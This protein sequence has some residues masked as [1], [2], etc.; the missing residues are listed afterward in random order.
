MAT[1]YFNPRFVFRIHTDLYA[2]NF[3]RVLAAYVTARHDGT[4]GQGLAEWVTDHEPE[5]R[6][7]F[8]QLC[9]PY[10]DDN[11][12]PRYVT[13]VPSPYFANDGY[14]NTWP[15]SEWMS[16]ACVDAY[17]EAS[18]YDDLPDRHDAYLSAGIYLTEK[19]EDH[20]LDL[21]VERTQTFFDTIVGQEALHEVEPMLKYTP[22]SSKIEIIGFDL[23]RYQPEAE[24]LWKR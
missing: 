3:E 1:E 10:P 12:F 15:Q 14:G 22:D 8:D 6:E 21:M 9:I 7:T 11:G 16:D 17:T 13:A 19:P 20:V 4:H 23:V 18:G 5:I 2:G 24:Q